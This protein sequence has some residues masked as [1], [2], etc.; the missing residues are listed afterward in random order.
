MQDPDFVRDTFAAIAGR[1]DL[2]NH[3]L[4]GGVDF[5]WRHRAAKLVAAHSPRTILDLATGSGDLAISLGKACPGAKVVGA[6]F[7][8]PM[9]IEA[10]RKDVP[11]LVTADGMRLPF[12]D[13]AFDALTVAFGLRNMA[14]WP[15]AVVEM[16]RV[17]RPG[18]LLLVMDFSLPTNPLLLPVYRFYLHHILPRIAASLT[19]NR[20][21]Y[22]YLAESIERFPRGKD[23]VG[24]IGRSG[25][26]GVRQ[27][28]LFFGVA[29]IYTA[30]R[31]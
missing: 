6:D 1:Y 14:S 18:G 23:M 16:G 22:D 11:R 5:W 7:C 21:A 27:I 20:G 10:K 12:R 4:S 31:S 29:S 9:L 8:H 3:A 26:G 17:L 28:P 19:G 30:T 13:A 24:L 2:A 15:D 25:F